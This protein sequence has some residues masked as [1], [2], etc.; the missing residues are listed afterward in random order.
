MILLI[1]IPCKYLTEDSVYLQY[2]VML[3]IQ[4][5]VS[6]NARNAALGVE[7]YET[8]LGENAPRPPLPYD[9]TPNLLSPQ[10]SIILLLPPLRNSYKRPC[11]I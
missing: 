4:K 11:N 6:E 2:N 3:C 1:N 9:T 7:K 10:L 5:S 8:F